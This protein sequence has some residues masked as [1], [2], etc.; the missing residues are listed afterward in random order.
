[1]IRSSTATLQR[2][3]YKTNCQRTKLKIY[4]FFNYIPCRFKR[5]LIN[6]VLPV[7]YNGH[8]AGLNCVTVPHK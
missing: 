1:M 5:T 3:F 8:E 2:L 7:F 4:I 6:T